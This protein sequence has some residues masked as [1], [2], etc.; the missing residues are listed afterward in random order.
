MNT[1]LQYDG[2]VPVEQETID[3]WIES[4]VERVRVNFVVDIEQ[5]IFCGDMDAWND[6]VDEIVGVS[7]TD[8]SYGFVRTAPEDDLP[9]I[10]TMM[11]V[12][13]NLDGL[14]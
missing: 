2:I 4:G 11:F 10:A 3:R 13:G 14:A 6:T 9:E 8:L 1:V 12:E 7:L 5:L